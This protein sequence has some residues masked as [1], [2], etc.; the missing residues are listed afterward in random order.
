MCSQKLQRAETLIG[1]LGGEKDRW[2]QAAE[3]FGLQYSN[4]TGDSLICAGIVAYLGPFTSSYRLK[5]KL[6]WIKECQAL[7][8]PCSDDFSVVKF[9][10]D[11][12]AIKAWIFAGLPT[13]NFSVENG[14]IIKYVNN[15][16]HFILIA[17]FS[18]IHLIPSMQPHL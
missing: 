10:G 5:Q 15:L 7:N 9:L 11:P 14:I 1:G 18:A 2:L 17:D 3:N 8:M 16:F 4:L 12:V 6:S 13:D